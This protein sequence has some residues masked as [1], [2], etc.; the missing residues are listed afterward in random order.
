MKRTLSVLF[1]AILLGSTH[2][3][4]AQTISDFEDI[5]LAGKDTTFLTMMA[6]QG[7]GYYPFESGNVRFYGKVDFDGSYQTFFNCSNITD[8]LTPE[9]TNQWSNIVGQGYEASSNYGVVYLEVNL[10]NFNESAEVGAKLLGEAAGNPVAGF[11]ITNTTYTYYYINSSFR[12][13]DYAQL[14]VRGYLNNQRTDDSVVFNLTDFTSGKSEILKSWKWINLLPLGN[15]DSITFQMR[16]SD[17]YLPYYFAFDNFTTTD[18]KCPIS[19]EIVTTNINENSVDIALIPSVENVVSR[20]Q[21]AIDESPTME[22][23]GTIITQDS[24]QFHISDLQPNTLYY[25]HVR[26]MCVDSGYSG[27]DTLSF[28]TLE[29]SF[30]ASGDKYEL[31]ISISPNPVRNL[32]NIHSDIPVNASIISLDGKKL[33]DYKAEK[34]LDVSF[35]ATGIYLI[36]IVDVKSGAKKIHKFIK[37]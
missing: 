15:V 6:V 30:I 9:W 7:D 11:Y 32:L 25:A 20:Y 10:E 21:L 27:W 16:S 22:P 8:T 1:I 28:H 35:L 14:I 2:S 5:T 12:D 31:N 34:I 33:F 4:Y 17:D 19:L 24:A 23:A 18:G 36:E 13:D 26:A 3:F 37:H 29:S